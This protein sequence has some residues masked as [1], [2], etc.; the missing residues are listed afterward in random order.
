MT[1]TT[2]TSTQVANKLKQKQHLQLSLVGKAPGGQQQMQ[3]A[4]EQAQQAGVL[5]N[6]G[7]IKATRYAVMRKEDSNRN[8]NGAPSQ[9]EPVTHANPQPQQNTELCID[10]RKPKRPLGSDSYKVDP[11]NTDLSEFMSNYQIP[12]NSNG[13][14]EPLE[15]YQQASQPPP[16][17]AHLRTANFTI[18]S[19]DPSGQGGHASELGV[20]QATHNKNYLTTDE[21]EPIKSNPDKVFRA[22]IR[23][24]V[25]GADW[26]VQFEACNTV[27]RV[28]KFHQDLV[29]QHGAT[30]HSLVK[31]LTKLADSLR[32]S[33]S[34]IALITIRDMF[35]F[36]KRCMETYL[37]PLIKIL[38]KRAADTSAFISEE[39]VQAL[40]TMTINCSDTKILSV[41]LS[42]P[43]NSK[44]TAQ[45]LS[46]CRCLEQLVT[47]LGN[48]I[49]FFKDSDKLIGQLANY[50]KD[51][52]QEVRSSSKRAFVSLS[53]AIMGQN[54]L[55]KLLLRV[56]NEEQYK[57]V[58]SFLD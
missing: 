22:A 30:L 21:L 16:G 29:L 46:V 37:D 6:R 23:E 18:L 52:C 35:Q 50:L 25:A 14:K 45:R 8:L 32:S 41:L 39:A 28:C 56:L 17:E 20:A 55:E 58:R 42:Q 27:R 26:N 51:A 36:L 12:K 49:L 31:Q 19:D 5:G 15:V 10:N 7:P 9:P 13:G 53:S 11:A 57:K 48:N 54:D 40:L 3:Q 1:N 2:T 38:L 4:E 43:L 33:L 24:L 34:K 44:S 47:N